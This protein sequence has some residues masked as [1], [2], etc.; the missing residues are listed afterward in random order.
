MGGNSK[1]AVSGKVLRA[2]GMSG[3]LAICYG[4]AMLAGFSSYE[5]PALR[6]FSVAMPLLPLLAALGAQGLPRVLPSLVGR[7]VVALLFALELPVVNRSLVEFFDNGGEY[8]L[9]S[10]LYSLAVLVGMACGLLLV[11]LRRVVVSPPT[12]VVVPPVHSLP[13]AT[14]HKTA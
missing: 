9:A 6:F 7:A 12:P 10:E 11:M 13:E 2:A 5:P 14:E 8:G 1:T 4:T 3:G